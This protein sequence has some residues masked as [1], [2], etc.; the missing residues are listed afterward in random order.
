M[1]HECHNDCYEGCEDDHAGCYEGCYKHSY[2]YKYKRTVTLIHLNVPGK[3]WIKSMLCPNCYLF[4]ADCPTCIFFPNP[5]KVQTTLEEI[6]LQ[7]PHLCLTQTPKTMVT[8]DLM[9]PFD[10]RMM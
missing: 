5:E 1:E 2:D 4:G 3:P 10:A 6:Q 9:H 7:F 8:W